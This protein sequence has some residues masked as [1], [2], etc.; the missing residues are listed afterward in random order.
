MVD[1]LVVRVCGLWFSVECL[2]FEVYGLR[3][4]VQVLWIG[5]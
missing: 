1:G 3:F 2:G 4:G 5:M